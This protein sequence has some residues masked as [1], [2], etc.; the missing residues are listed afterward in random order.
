METLLRHQ[1]K[2]ASRCNSAQ[3]TLYVDSAVTPQ[4]C[5][6][7][8]Q[9]KLHVGMSSKNRSW[10]LGRNWSTQCPFDSGCLASVGAHHRNFPRAHHCGTSQ[11]YC[12][13]HIGGCCKPT[14]PNL[15]GF[16][17]VVKLDNFDK[18]GIVEIRYRWVLKCN[19][20]VLPNTDACQIYRSC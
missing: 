9:P 6:C 2:E 12:L 11:R 16:T 20:P 14:L 19:V 4:C 10:A 3:T 8:I 5:R 15:L 17:C 7:L 1:A 13:W 18:F